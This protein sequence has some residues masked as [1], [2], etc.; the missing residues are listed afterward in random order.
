[1]TDDELLFEAG[2]AAYTVIVAS[3]RAFGFGKK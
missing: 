1:M 2:M 3:S